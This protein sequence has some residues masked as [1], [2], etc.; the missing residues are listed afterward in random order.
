MYLYQN[1][2]MLFPDGKVRVLN[3]QNQWVEVIPLLPQPQQQLFQTQRV[4]QPPVQSEERLQASS[5]SEEIAEE[6]LATQPTEPEL[7]ELPTKSRTSCPVVEEEDNVSMASTTL[8]SA[9]LSQTEQAESESG[10][11]TDSVE[12]EPDFSSIKEKEVQEEPTSDTVTVQKYLVTRRVQ[13]RTGPTAASDNVCV[14]RQGQRVQVVKTKT[15]KTKAGFITTKAYIL[16]D[17]GQGWVSINRQNKKIDETFVFKG[18]V[19]HG[20]QKILKRVDV[21]SRHQAEVGKVSNTSKGTF[22]VCVTCPT[23][24]QVEALRADLC[25]NGIRAGLTRTSLVNKRM[26]QLVNLKRIFGNNCPT[27]HVFGIDTDAKNGHMDFLQAFD[28]SQEFQG[29]SN[30]FQ[31]Q[32]KDDL[33]CLY[34]GV[35]RVNWATG[36]TKRSVTGKV[37]SLNMRD[38]C[39]VEFAKDSQLRSFLK[40]FEEYDFFQGAQVKVDPSYANLA[41]VSAELVKLTTV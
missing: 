5:I 1:T 20:A 19:S 10:M 41:T 29:S 31:H 32:L 12:V 40:K 38:Y 28:W 6:V 9:D 17:Q 13:V 25:A 2:P 36:I 33:L 11:T 15:S 21:W 14:L 35:R 3:Q 27:V 26:P 8:S 18:R 23:W 37:L 30:S 22:T 34:A 16:S 39:T 7:A 4:S 24:Q